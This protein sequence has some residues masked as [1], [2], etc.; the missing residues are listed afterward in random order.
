[1][2]L[3]RTLRQ[4]TELG[5]ALIFIAVMTIA[6]CGGGG[7]GS[8]SSN[9]SLVQMGGA[10]QGV[11]LNLTT[12]VT[13]F[14]GTGAALSYP[15]G[16]TTDGTNLYV[17]DSFNNTI[18]KIVLSSGAV[19]LLA[20]SSVAGS[21]DNAA[22]TL[23]Q[24][25][26][27]TDITTDGTNLFVVD[28]PNHTI[29]KIVISSGA[30]TTLAGLVGTSGVAD[31]ASGIPAKFNYPYGIT[32]DGSNLFVTDSSSNTIRKIVIATGAVTTLA[33][34]SAAAAGAMDA[35]GTSA[36]FNNPL[37]V[38][39]D[40]TYLYV[41][42]AFNL[43]IRKVTISNGAV[44]TLAGSGLMGLVDNATGTLAKFY[45]PTGIT[46]DGT[47]LYVADE[48]NNAIR[49]VVISSGAVT[50]IAGNWLPGSTDNTGTAA[51][52]NRPQGITTDGVSLYI[53]DSSNNKI[54]KIQ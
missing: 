28:S 50:T 54:R 4:T 44:A 6:G 15:L 3:N 17:A 13:T 32:T 18:R 52:F 53:S 14:V 1:M 8:S 23:A 37:G 7:S 12:A 42:D 27:P 43:K 19:T 24:F 26:Q 30:V 29:R 47:N 51:S 35:T 16:I 31:T 2:G 21:A 20:G 41:A 38:T 40:G 10:R 9:G 45:L 5:L 48:G 11:S 34:S 25:W 49:K 39:T 36:T 33:G 46:T 22:G